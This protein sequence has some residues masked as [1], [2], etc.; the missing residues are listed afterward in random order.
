MTAKH[1]Y[2]RNW[3][4]ALGVVVT[5]AVYF[6]FFPGV[7]LQQKLT[8]ITDFSWFVIFVV[9]YASAMDTIGR[10]IASRIDIV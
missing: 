4:Q 8:F 6:S 1:V 7:I 5:D 3:V 9:T 2:R 10:F